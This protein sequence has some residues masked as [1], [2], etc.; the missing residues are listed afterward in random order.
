M[1][2]H[3]NYIHIIS[4]GFPESKMASDQSNFVRNEIREAVREEVSRLLGS[5]SATSNSTATG[6]ESNRESNNERPP[7][8]PQS[9]SFSDCPSTST[10]RTRTLSFEDF[11]KMRESQR[12]SGFKVSKKKKKGLSTTSNAPKKST[13]VEIKVGIA[14]QT[15]GV[16]KVRRCKTLHYFLSDPTGWCNGNFR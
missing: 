12:Q 8:T 7:V 16:V 3:T 2:A 15:D 5:T 14:A 4:R 1:R 10:R 11:Y 13:N 6:N 9:S